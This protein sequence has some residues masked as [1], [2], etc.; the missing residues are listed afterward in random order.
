MKKVILLLFFGFTSMFAQNVNVGLGVGTQNNIYKDTKSNVLPAPVIS[1]Q[2]QYMYI[3]AE[4][5]GAFLY[6]NGVV[7]LSLGVQA[8]IE[9]YDDAKGYMQGMKDRGYTMEGGLKVSVKTDFGNFKIAGYHDLLGRYEGYSG[10]LEYSYLFKFDKFGFSPY[11]GLDFLSDDF[12]DYYFGVKQSEVRANRPQYSGD[13]TINLKTGIN[14][15]YFIN[16]SWSVFGGAAIAFFGDEIKDSP[17]VD[18]DY[19]VRVGAGISYRF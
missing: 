14:A 8:R 12:V 15:Y 9:G 1:Y 16:D 19:R 6:Q 18:K 17:I 3:S 13:S 7:F 4:E 10:E 5:A 11:V 2:N